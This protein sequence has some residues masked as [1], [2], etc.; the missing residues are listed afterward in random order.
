MVV[1]VDMKQLA[2]FDCLRDD[3]IEIQARHLF[4]PDFGIHANH[5]RVIEPGNKTEHRA[6]RRQ[7]DIA[8]RLIRFG[9]ERKLIVIALIY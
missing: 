9:F 2:C 6:R 4:V 7:I 3:V 5:L 1:E 8:A